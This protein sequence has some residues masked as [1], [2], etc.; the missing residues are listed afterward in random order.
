[1]IL[2]HPTPIPPLTP[3][4]SLPN[5]VLTN[6]N[7]SAQL[8]SWASASHQKYWI[9]QT[10][11]PRQTLYGY[12]PYGYYLI[13]FIIIESFKNHFCFKVRQRQLNL[14][15]PTVLQPSLQYPATIPLS[16]SFIFHLPTCSENQPYNPY[17]HFV[18]LYLI[19]YSSIF[20]IFKKPSYSP[21]QKVFPLPQPFSQF[22]LHQGFN[23]REYCEAWHWFSIPSLLEA[24][25]GVIVF[26]ITDPLSLRLKTLVYCR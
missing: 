14:H 15:H 19:S 13:W 7:S 26:T 10:K 11:C 25:I 17:Q 23:E 24:W 18:P 2:Q 16:T 21:N 3:L 22:K 1:M 12:I 6:W 8:M 20:Y 9:C 4:P 5:F